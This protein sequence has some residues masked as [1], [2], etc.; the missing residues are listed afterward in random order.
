MTARDFRAVPRL[1]VLCMSREQEVSD[2]YCPYA[3][4]SMVQ[5]AYSCTKLTKQVSVVVSTLPPP[6]YSNSCICY[7][8]TLQ[9]LVCVFRYF[10]RKKNN[11]KQT[12]ILD[13]NLYLEIKNLPQEGLT[14]L[15]CNTRAMVSRAI[16]VCYIV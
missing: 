2:V 10:K 15:L 13:I 5:E 14:E 3:P 4:T 7:D 16:R 12:T 9:F 1:E 8:Y 6:V 11:N